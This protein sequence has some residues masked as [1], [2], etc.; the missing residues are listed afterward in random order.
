V[1][2]ESPVRRVEESRSLRSIWSVRFAQLNPWLSSVAILAFVG[3][4]L[5]HFNLIRKTSV[6]IPWWDDWAL[7]GGNHPSHLDWSWLYEQANDHRTATTKLFVW[8]L[9]HLDGWNLRTSLILSFLIYGVCVAWMVWIARK[10]DPKLPVWV[11]LGFAIFL[12]SPISWIVHVMGYGVADHLWLLFM[13]IAV[14]CMF[15]EPQSWLVLFLGSM[16]SIL[17][18][19]SFG[20]GVATAVVLL[21]GF[22]LF[23]GLRAYSAKDPILRRRELLQLLMAVGMIGGALAIWVGGWK[24]TPARLPWVLPHH[25]KF[26][27]FFLNLVAFSFGIERVSAFWG[28]ICLLIVITPVCWII[29]KKRTDLRSAHWTSL[30]LVLSLLANLALISLGRAEYGIQT[31]KFTHYSEHGMPLILFSAI[32]WS[33][34]LAARP[35][36][37]VFVL[38]GLWIFCLMTFRSN[39]DFTIYQKIYADKME[40]KRC[41]QAY[42]EKG[43]FDQTGADARC[44]T[45]FPWPAPMA[46]VLEQAKKAN[47]S[48]YRDLKK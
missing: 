9:Y 7:V 35:R 23:K 15:R 19:Y 28:L 17:S 46:G 10:T 40:G 1:N 47:P 30:V 41:V 2:S 27:S 32:N 48:F 20:A 44:P 33:L 43:G 24:R 21:A 12:L 11:I 8:A 3:I 16:A 25:L 36:V 42:Y 14:S 29:A 37:K 18:M 6:D 4:F 39:W 34:L 22:S 45:V 26:W 38:A 13:L 5:Y 31:A